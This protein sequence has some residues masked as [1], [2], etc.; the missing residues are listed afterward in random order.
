MNYADK[1]TVLFNKDSYESKIYD[2]ATH[3]EGRDYNIEI[4]KQ[5]LKE[6][7]D[8]MSSQDATEFINYSGVL[9]F[10]MN[11][12]F[13]STYSYLATLKFSSSTLEEI[14]IWLID[15]LNKSDSIK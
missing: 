7:L 6:L 5:I 12:M 4:G 9:V 10:I 14:R 2:I 13:S 11:G 8:K 1:E 15:V 3:Y